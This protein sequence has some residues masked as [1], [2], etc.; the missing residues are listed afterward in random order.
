MSILS[1]LRGMIQHQAS[2]LP[3]PNSP[4]SRHLPRRRLSLERLEERTC[5]SIDLL[6]TSY[7]NS[8][9]LRYNG[10]T[11]AFIGTFARGRKTGTDLGLTFGPDANLYVDGYETNNVV[12]HNG[13]TGKVINVFV[14][15]KS[16]GLCGAEGMA[17]GADDNLYVSNDTT[18][19]LCG[20]T[21]GNILRYNGATGAFIDAFVPSGSGGLSQA[22]DLHFGPDGHLYV[23]SANTNSVLRYNETTGAFIDVFVPSGS[24]GLSLANGFTWGRDGNLYI[25]S[26]NNDTVKRYNGT[27]GAY[28]DDFVT[29]GSGGLDFGDGLVF[30]PD[31]NLYVN[32]FSTNS[33]KRY[34]GTT[35]A[36][37]D[38]FVAA[39]SGG[40]SGSATLLF[41]DFTGRSQAPDHA[42][43]LATAV[44][45]V[46]HS[47]ASE[48]SS[49]GEAALGIHPG[50][51]V[52]SVPAQESTAEVT[53]PSTPLVKSLSPPDRL[54]TTDVEHGGLETTAEWTAYL[55][56]LS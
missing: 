10:S 9:V 19:S 37:I 33:V 13:A 36:Y 2:R 29:A 56:V 17:F 54:H 18:S 30:G 8:L 41:H 35:G 47:L 15:P 46:S 34:N 14:P 20:S 11:G 50:V 51:I 32:S 25:N 27:T 42:A 31:G 6:V 4:S 1:E 23:S 43:A 26:S 39:G 12:R 16:G 22:N 40:L 49:E 52:T 38:D 5:P 7:F 28:I 45:V 21:P 48:H 44:S 3:R 53:H 24:G 55:N